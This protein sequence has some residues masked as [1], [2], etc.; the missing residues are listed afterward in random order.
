MSRRAHP[1]GG[2]TLIEL[3]VVIAIIA[4]LAAILFPVFAK[5]REKARTSTCQSNLKQFGTAILQYCQDNDE[6]MPLIRQ[7]TAPGVG[8]PT[9]RILCQ[10][11]LKSTQVFACPSNTRNTTPANQDSYPISYAAA[12]CNPDAGGAFKYNG[13]GTWANDATVAI[14]SMVTP[15][16]TIMVCESLS[17]NNGVDIV[18]P[19]TSYTNPAGNNGMFAGHNAMG[20]FLF[21]DGHVKTSKALATISVAMGGSGF[22]NMWTIDN[23]DFTS[24]TNTGYARGILRATDLFWK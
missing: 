22:V 16:S 3:L 5:A 13:T 11:Y 19:G 12:R 1:R 6:V 7:E 8:G 4:I 14:S 2:F 18:D 21:C 9:W 17:A 23:R 10:P 20:N 24:G 15:A